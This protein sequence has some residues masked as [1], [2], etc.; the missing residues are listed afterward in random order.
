MRLH[1]CDLLFA[2]LRILVAVGSICAV[3][4]APIPGNV[5]LP[6]LVAFVICLV[7]YKMDFTN[8]WVVFSLPWLLILLF[9]VFDISEYSRPV[10]RETILSVVVVLGIGLLLLPTGGAVARAGK[11]VRQLRVNDRMFKLLLA[12]Y[13]AFCILNIALAGYVPLL[14]AIVEGDSGYMDFGIKGVYGLFNAFANAFGLTAFYLWMTSRGRSLYKW[15][16]F[17]VLA[18]FFVFVTR[19]NMVSLLVESFIVYCLVVRKVSGLWIAALALTALFGF[20]AIG[21]FRV[22][23]DIAQVAAVKDEFLWV[24][25]SLI[26]LFTYCYFNL[27]NLDNVVSASFVPAYDG[28]SLAQLLPSFMRPEADDSESLLEVSSFTVNSFISPIYH[29][30][31]IVG[32]CVVFSI[33]CLAVRWYSVYRRGV[34]PFIGIT[35]YAVLYFCFFFSF[36]VNFWFYLPVIF[37]LAFLPIFQKLLFRRFVNG[38]VDKVRNAS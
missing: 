30:F 9:S 34:N 28:S 1:K 15:S 25:R 3:A 29:D 5:V 36:F 18:V 4:F 32:L 33:F 23:V 35:G 21:D 14:R 37:Q 24:P 7:L 26:W 27:L 13:V 17:L 19:Q 11:A 22:G 16:F 10:G 12:G 31:Q 2:S 8:I 38:R 6:V 20:A